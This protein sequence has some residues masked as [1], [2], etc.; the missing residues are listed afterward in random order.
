MRWGRGGARSASSR[1]SLKAESKR[2]KAER[3]EQT[4]FCFLLSAVCF[5][6][7]AEA[8]ARGKAL[9]RKCASIRQRDDEDQRGHR[10]DPDPDPLLLGHAGR[11]ELLEVLRQLMQ[12]L[13]RHLRE[14]LIDLLSRESVRGE[15]GRD[16]IVRRDGA[17]S[18]QIRVTRV[19]ALIGCGLRWDRTGQSRHR[20]EGQQKNYHEENEQ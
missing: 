3:S 15:H 14:P 2:Q 6:A 12:I 16:L 5:R 20:R 4:N 13:R 17:N 18:R 9:R 7:S 8:L 1:R 10:A 19:E 11:L